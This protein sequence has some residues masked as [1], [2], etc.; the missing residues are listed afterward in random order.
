MSA[1]DES[2]QSYFS[3]VDLAFGALER[4][5]ETEGI[6]VKRHNLIYETVKEHVGPLRHAFACWRLSAWFADA[7]RIDTSDSGFPLFRHVLQLET[8]R[9]KIAA[10]LAALPKPDQIREEMVE[11]MLKAKTFPHKLQKTMGERL[12]YTALGKSPTFPGHSECRTV[13]HFI[14]KTSKRPYY[15]V[16]WSCYDGSANLPMVYMAVIEDSSPDAPP[17]A[18]L[19]SGPWGRTKAQKDYLGRGLPN[20]DLT[21]DFNQFITANSQYSLNLTSIATAMDHDF[22]T[23]HPKNLRRFILGPLNIGGLTENDPRL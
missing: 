7:F 18:Q 10:K 4:I 16:H 17:P 13:G 14:D 15:V 23:L 6:W 2:I 12:Y 21:R 3:S 22:P 11:H 19:K 9:K 1:P 20:R 8:D 5:F